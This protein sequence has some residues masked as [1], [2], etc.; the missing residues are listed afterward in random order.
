MSSY[1]NETRTPP[2]HVGVILASILLIIVGYAGLYI[3]ITTQIPRVGPRWIFFVCLFIAVAGTVMPVIRYLNV[4]FTP[5]GKR[6]PNGG[7]I[8]RQSAWVGLFVVTCFWL[9][10]PRVLSL[11]IMFFLALALVIIEIFL[12]SRELARS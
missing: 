6:L 12:R 7:I 8:V 3:I 1:S 4:R 11:P 2:D 5:V 9:Q 10:I